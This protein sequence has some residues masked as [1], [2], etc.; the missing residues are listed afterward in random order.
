MLASS[1]ED[2]L[3]PAVRGRRGDPAARWRW[4]WAPA[5][6]RAHSGLGGFLWCKEGPCVTPGTRG[7][8]RRPRAAYSDSLLHPQGCPTQ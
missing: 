6:R 4:A 3:I 7:R 1:Q 8:A 5:G 2:P